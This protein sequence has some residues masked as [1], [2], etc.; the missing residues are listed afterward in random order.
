MKRAA[1]LDHLRGES[2]AQRKLYREQV[3]QAQQRTESAAQRLQELRRYRNEYVVAFDARL[4]E[5]MRGAGFRDYQAFLARLDTAI[6]QQST[7]LRR[8]ETDLEHERER[9][10]EAAIQVKSL[11]SIAQRWC[12]EDDLIAQRAEQKNT[13]EDAMRALQQQAVSRR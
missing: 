10:R 2:E 5:G 13:D 3:L 6:A 1:R 4:S 9:L 11:E 7:L 8:A 12:R